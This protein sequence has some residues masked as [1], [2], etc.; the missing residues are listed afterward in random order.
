MPWRVYRP[1]IVVGDSQTGAMDKVDGP[2]YFFPLIKRLRDN[3]PVV[4]AAGR[5][6][7]GRH[8]RGAGRLR[9]QGD[10]PPRPPARPRRRGLPPGQPRAA[11]GGRDDQRVLRRRRRAAV[12]H[13]DRPQ[14]HRAGALGC[15]RGRCGPP[16][17]STQWCGRRRR[18]SLLDQTL[19][20]L[21]I[22]AEVLAPHVVHRPS[23]TPGA[24]RRRWPAPGSPS[25]TSRPTRARCGAT[26]RRTSTRPP[27][28][29]RRTARRSRASTS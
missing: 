11:A 24:P 9:R 4:A 15:S 1:A 17:C 5:R 28:A 26:G 29:T 14:R 23:S 22:P 12:R 18:R 6:R 27:A 10:G 7:P 3:L 8:Q 19:G 20:R 13:P 16:T 21:G 25:P 2:Y